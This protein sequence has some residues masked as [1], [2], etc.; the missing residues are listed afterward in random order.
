MTPPTYETVDG[1]T[2]EITPLAA[3]H[4]KRLPLSAFTLLAGGDV[5][6]ARNGKPP[7]TGQ[8]APAPT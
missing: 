7:R 4:G 6:E 3:E 2:P 5:F 1:S 8:P